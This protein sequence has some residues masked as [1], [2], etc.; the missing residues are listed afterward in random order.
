MAQPI[1]LRAGL[2]AIAFLAHRQMK[3]LIFGGIIKVHMDLHN[4]LELKVELVVAS[5]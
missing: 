3:I 5:L 4:F 2:E 1:C